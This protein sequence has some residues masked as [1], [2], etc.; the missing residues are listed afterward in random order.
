[1]RIINFVIAVIFLLM[2][3]S[4]GSYVIKEKDSIPQYSDS[5]KFVLSVQQQHTGMGDA[6]DIYC[7]SFK[8][9]GKERVDIY[10]GGSKSVIEALIIIPRSNEEYKIPPKK[11]PSLNNIM[12]IANDALIINGDTL[13]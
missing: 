2:V 13:I 9:H 12:D 3:M 5:K 4:C 10:D 7:D 6:I 8:F 1:M 11:K